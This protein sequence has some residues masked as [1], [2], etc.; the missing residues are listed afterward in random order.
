M[1]SLDLGLESCNKSVSFG[2]E[3]SFRSLELSETHPKID[4]FRFENKLL[5]RTRR[6]RASARKRGSIQN[7]ER[8]TH[9]SV[10]SLLR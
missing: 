9:L 4:Q 7:E 5:Q 8:A 3:G 6:E 1:E 10:R 2:D